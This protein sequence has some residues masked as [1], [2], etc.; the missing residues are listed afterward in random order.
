[1]AR[2]LTHEGCSR[3]VGAKP[4]SA[5]EQPSNTSVLSA[6]SVVSPVPRL[7]LSVTEAA[8]AL[9]VSVDFLAEHV[10]PELRWCRR[11]RKKLV[12]VSELERWLVE[13]SARVFE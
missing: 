13:N 8:Q 12:A 6:P 1:M 3:P 2:P 4:L 7:A 9:G 10:A 11:G 5:L